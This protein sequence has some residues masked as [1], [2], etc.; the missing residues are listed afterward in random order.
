M[1]LDFV[2]GVFELGGAAAAWK[3]AL[4]LNRDKQIKGVYWPVYLFYSLWGLWN[5][6]Y[7]PALDQWFSF[8]AGTAL[9]AGN[10]AW[11]ALALRYRRRTS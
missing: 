2:N 8:G 10:V 3:N 6:V 11:V 4:Q 1:K 7:Y 5:L 9:V